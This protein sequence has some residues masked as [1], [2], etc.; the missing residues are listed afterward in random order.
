M[1]QFIERLRE[2]E[3]AATPAPWIVE[4]AC[5]NG[6]VYRIAGEY[7]PVIPQDAKLIAEMRNALPKLLAVVEA[8]KGATAERDKIK[9]AGH[10]NSLKH[11][12]AALEES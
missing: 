7:E 4:H 9:R 10:I 2:L 11:A 12:L 6:P 5:V 8:A 1:K 3:E